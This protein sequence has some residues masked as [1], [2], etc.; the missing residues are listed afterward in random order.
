MATAVLSKRW[1]EGGSKGE[2]R[3]LDGEWKNRQYSYGFPN[4][5]GDGNCT[6]WLERLGLL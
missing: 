1:G 2:R 3:S 4:R 5:D 6:T